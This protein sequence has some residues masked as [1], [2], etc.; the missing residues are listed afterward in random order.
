MSLLKRVFTSKIVKNSGWIVGGKIAQMIIAFMVGVFT[1]RYLGP[2]NYG[3]INTAQA[4]T[5]FFFP[6]CSLGLSGVI[7]KMLLDHPGEDGKFLGSGIALRTV[8]SLT[9]TILMLLVVVVMN[10]SDRTL[11]IV[12]FIHSFALLFQ[13]FDLFD[14]WYQSRYESKYS[15]LIGIIGYTVSAIYKV[16]L[17][18]SGKSVEWFAFAT[19]LDYAVIAAIY[20]TYTI[21]KNRIK[22]KISWKTALYMFSESKHLI[23]ANLLVVLYGQMDKIMIGKIESSESVGLYSVAVTICSMWTFVLAAIINSL[24]PDIVCLRRADRKAYE[25]RI[26]QLYSLVF[27]ISTIVS[28]LI[29]LSSKFIIGFLYGNEYLGA[30]GC[31][32]IVTWYTGFSYLG[33]AR[34]VWTVCEGKQKYEKYFAIVGIVSN[35]ILNC[36]FIPAWG[37]EGA[38]IASLITQIVTNVI[39]PYVIKETRVNSMY[40]FKSFNPLHLFRMIRS[41]K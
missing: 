21:K 2:S 34:N 14:Y 6:I 20:M 26:I 37:I 38:A 4:Y 19:V 22:L 1:A 7:V 15:S 12:C 11:Q 13:A 8:S 17:L 31:L 32:N 29:C 33:V 10:P 27:W 5:A 28:L 41:I 36:L 25:N 35:L 18:I 24:R 23:L 30:V 9:A 16:I 3:I 39:T 40:V